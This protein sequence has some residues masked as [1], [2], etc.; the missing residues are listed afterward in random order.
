MT[1]EERTKLI[2]TLKIS[3]GIKHDGQND[4]F[5]MVTALFDGDE[6]IAL[7]WFN[8]PNR[9]LHWKTPAEIIDSEEGALMV[10]TLIIRIEQGVYS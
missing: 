8:E 6:D 10:T 4:F 1:Q 9:A 5:Q 7:N 2:K 3:S